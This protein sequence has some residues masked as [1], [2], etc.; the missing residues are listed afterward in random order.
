M[1]QPHTAVCRVDVVRGSSVTTF[2]PLSGSVVYDFDD[3]T[4]RSL[5]VQLI[6]TEQRT[7]TQMESLTDPFVAVLKPYRGI[8]FDQAGLDVEWV[9]L[10]TFFTDNLEIGESTGGAVVWQLA[11]LDESSR[12]MTPFES[13]RFVPV[14][15]PI[16]QA[17]PSII[18]AVWPKMQFALAA[19]KFTTPNLL[20]TE[21]ANPWD[22]A[23][24]LAQASGNDL[25]LRRD[26]VCA[27][28]ARPY[29]ISPNPVDPI[30][31]FVEGQTATFFDPKRRVNTRPP[32]VIVVVGTNSQAPGVRA[33]AADMDPYSPTY[34]QGPYGRVVEVVRSE[35][36]VSLDQ[37]RAY[38]SLLLS[39][40]LGP[41]DEATFSCVPNPAIDEAD[42][43]TITRARLG[44]NRERRLV[45]HLEIPLDVKTP[46][47]VTGRRSV[48]TEGR[49]A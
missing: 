23:M 31:E 43:V 22:E 20:L 2:K 32:N 41:Q 24:R 6:D 5:D 7:F 30:L 28:G 13:P 9:P 27:M 12:A 36:V 11:A 3:M 21:D 34:S 14:G 39:L 46:M 1:T 49:A 44:M 47:A 38:A 40:R 10:G 35:L 26:G 18:A 45:S 19:S 33:E 25:Y 15:T 4:R 17:V 16:Q 29:T 37:A 8:Q 42:T 48:V